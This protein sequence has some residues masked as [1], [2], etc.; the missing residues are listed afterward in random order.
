MNMAVGVCVDDLLGL[1]RRPLIRRECPS[2]GNRRGF[3][4]CGQIS[5]IPGPTHLHRQL[6]NMAVD[7]KIDDLL[8]LT[9]WPRK[10]GRAWRSEQLPKHLRGKE[11]GHRAAR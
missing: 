4:Q 5:M 9:C 8:G 7:V 11:S 3:R 2:Q 6:M 1:S 10:I